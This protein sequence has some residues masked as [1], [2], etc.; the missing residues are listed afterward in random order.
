[1]NDGSNRLDDDTGEVVLM[2]RGERVG[3]GPLRRELASTY[4]RW[5]NDLHVI[6]TLAQPR[7]PTTLAAEHSWLDGALTSSDAV[8][9][10]YE[11][12][13]HRPIGNT[14]LH[15][16]N[17]TNQTCEFGI[18]IGERDAWGKG[19][20]GEATRLML[21]YAFDVLGLYNVSLA[22]YANN[23]RAIRAYQRAGFMQAGVL[24][25]A[26]R[27]GRE[28]VDEIIMDAIADDFP[29]SELHGILHPSNSGS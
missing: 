27:I 21:A 26:Q 4:Q 8:F 2:I 3:L 5:I 12:E 28:R 18:L 22:V 24:R 15:G 1:V 13:T 10:I 7:R 29:R 19:F 6:R 16:I 9:T 20:G 14:G 11:L 23:T 25:G 17:M